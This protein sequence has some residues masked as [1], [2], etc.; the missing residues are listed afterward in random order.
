M[1]NG[2]LKRNLTVKYTVF[3]NAV[4]FGEK[5]SFR[6]NNVTIFK[7]EDQANQ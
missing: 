5:P 6:R 4:Q 7:V 1:S 2:A 3:C